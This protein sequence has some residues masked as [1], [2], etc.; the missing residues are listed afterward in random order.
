MAVV[1]TCPALSCSSTTELSFKFSVRINASISLVL[2][3]KITPLVGREMIKNLSYHPRSNQRCAESRRLQTTRL[4]QAQSQGVG[5]SFTPGY[6]HLRYIFPL[7]FM[8]SPIPNEPSGQDSHCIAH[9]QSKT[10]Q[11]QSEAQ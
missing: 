8:N 7:S 2:P 6:Y 5:Q 1:M 4:V 9:H 3:P 10:S 11:R